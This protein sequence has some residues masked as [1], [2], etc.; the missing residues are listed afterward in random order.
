MTQIFRRAASLTKPLLAQ[1]LGVSLLAASL[2]GC[3]VETVQRT[4][5]RAS[6]PVP[7]ATLALMAE[8]QTDRNAPVLIRAY[9]KEAEIEIWKQNRKGDYVLLKSYPVCRW[10][11]QLGP[12][13][14]EGDRQVPEGFY[15]VSASQMNPFSSYW[16]AF[17]VGYPNPLEKSMGRSGGDIMVHGTCSS[18]GCFAMTDAQIEELHNVGVRGTRF[19]FVA[20]LG[21]A[22]DPD[23]FWTIVRRVER[24]GWHIVLHFDAKDLPQY[25][26]MLDRMPTPYVID[27]MGTVDAGKGLDQTN[28]NALIAAGYTYT[29]ALAQMHPS[30]VNLRDAYAELGISAQDAGL[31]QL[32]IQD[33]IRSSCAGSKRCATHPVPSVSTAEPSSDAA[34]TVPM[35]SPLNPRCSRYAGSTTKAMPSTNARTPRVNAQAGR[36]HWSMAQCILFAGGGVKP[37]QI[38]GETDRQAAA[39]TRDPVSVADLLHTVQQAVAFGGR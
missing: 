30:I 5:A 25:A 24:F 20:H 35:R 22:P 28:F 3:N 37:G 17:N 4:P 29:E 13:R 8:K 9:K 12:K 31:Q 33:A 2:A 38:I 19:N 32:M 6:A 27:H 26:S 1:A 34:T 16:L 15:T 11:G 10:S 21:G 7:Q 18:R 36:D 14:K 39:P 23:D